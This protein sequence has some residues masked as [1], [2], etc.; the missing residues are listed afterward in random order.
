MPAYAVV[1][2]N[3]LAQLENSL[4][5]DEDRLQDKLDQAFR[6]LD[7]LQPDLGRYL[8][9]ELSK[10]TDD[11]AQSLGY[12]LIVTVFMAFR[13]AFPTRLGSVTPD[14]LEAALASLAADEALRAEDPN[15][16]LESDDVL[17]M[18]Q[19]ALIDFVQEHVQEALE[20]SPEDTNLDDLD[21]VYRAILVEVI[22]LSHAV[23]PGPGEP[24]PIADGGDSEILA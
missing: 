8:T 19:P 13:E 5:E 23:Q 15:E 2:E 16:V 24:E 12:F 10:S 4:D 11:I 22:A 6:E 17:A 1:D 9:E 20:V 3:A 14:G 21:N 7:R 18:G